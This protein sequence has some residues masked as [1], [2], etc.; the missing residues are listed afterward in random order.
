MSAALTE[1]RLYGVLAAKYGPSRRYA[2]S[3]PRAAYKALEAN[4]GDF[5]ET[6]EDM[7]IRTVVSRGDDPD[8]DDAMDLDLEHIPMKTGTLTIHI[9]PMP[10]GAV[11]NKGRGGFKGFLGTILIATAVIIG[12]PAGLFS[13][14][15][16]IGIN[17]VLSGVS[18]LLM[19]TPQGIDPNSKEDD[20]SILFTSTVNVAAQGHA[21]P[22][23]YGGPIKVGSVVV[24]AGFDTDQLRLPNGVTFNALTDTYSGS[25]TPADYWTW[26]PYGGGGRYEVP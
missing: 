20:S 14:M 9:V 15:G 6:I 18:L 23:V 24:S 22:I 5:F 26:T 10:A 12:G 3:S 16:L 1:I 21:V 8:A 4:L 11:N 19:P 2:V 17:L 25:P 7:T 13:P